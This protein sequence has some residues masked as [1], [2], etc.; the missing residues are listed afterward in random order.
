[1]GGHL[2]HGPANRGRRHLRA[3]APLFVCEP[4]QAPCGGAVVVHGMLGLAH[5]A[6][7]ACRRLAAAGWLTAAPFLYHGH[8]G[9]VFGE[10]AAAAAGARAELAGLSLAEAGGDVAAAVSYLA[11]RGCPDAVVLGFGTGGYLAAWS[12]SSLAPAAPPGPARSGRVV[13]AV[14][15]AA[16]DLGAAGGPGRGFP[17]LADL[18]GTSGAPLLELAGHLGELRTWQ[19]IGAFLSGYHDDLRGQ[20]R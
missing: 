17:P 9:P 12:A 4:P 13:A 1:M 18:A 6:E 10:S 20:Q 19:R 8:G 16:V 3:A 14:A 2:A 5:D 7:A 15:V 11:G